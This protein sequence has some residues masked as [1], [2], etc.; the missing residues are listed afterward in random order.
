[1]R[2]RKVGRGGRVCEVHLAFETRQRIWLFQK[3]TYLAPLVCTGARP[4]LTSF[5]CCVHGYLRAVWTMAPPRE[6]LDV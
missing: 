1:M 4:A 2:A 6:K 5:L 3:A